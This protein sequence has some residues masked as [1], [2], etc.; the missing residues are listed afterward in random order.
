MLDKPPWL[1]LRRSGNNA[2]QQTVENILNSLSLNTVCSAAN[3]P[4]YCECFSKKTATFMIMGNNCTRKCTFCN[5]THGELSPLNPQEPINIALA[6][7]ELDLN[8][9]VITSV[10][11]DDLPDGGA[12]HFTETIRQIKKISTK[13]SIEVL[14]PDMNNNYNSLKLICNAG[15]AVICHNME[16]VR[17]L[18]AEVRPQANYQ[19]S[20]EVLAQVKQISPL[21]HSKSGFMLGLGETKDEVLE[22][23]SDLRK[24]NVVF[25]TIGQ[26]LAPSK[27]HLPVAEYVTPAQFTE[28]GEIAKKMG[29]T[30]VASAPLVRSS[31]M[32]HQAIAT[33]HNPG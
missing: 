11:R 14:L 4:N 13:T 8:Y 29:F 6:V 12:S 32:A 24:A 28:Y 1:R 5:V 20:L 22:L 19:R 30:H 2:N 23:L 9:V 21:I 17:R 16:T 25:I 33:L 10:T 18:Y 3:C 31:Y 27:H 7:K 26:Y 15:P